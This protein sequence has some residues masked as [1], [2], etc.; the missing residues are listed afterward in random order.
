MS[1]QSLQSVQFMRITQS[2][3]CVAQ[4]RV[5]KM[6]R[7][8]SVRESVIQTSL[9]SELILTLLDQSLSGCLVRFDQLRVKRERHTGGGKAKHKPKPQKQNE[10]IGYLMFHADITTINGQLTCDKRSE[11]IKL[12]KFVFTIIIS[13]SAVFLRTQRVDQ[14]VQNCMLSRTIMHQLGAMMRCGL[15]DQR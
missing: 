11:E 2:I 5:R 8:M 14:R 1:V 7:P 10:A 13:C 9:L 3:P 12:S 6:D 4:Q 15:E